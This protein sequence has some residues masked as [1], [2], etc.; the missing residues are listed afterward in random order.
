MVVRSVD[1]ETW[2]L[3]HIAICM[4]RTT[5]PITGEPAWW[6]DP[7]LIAPDGEVHEGVIDFLLRPLR[8]P[9]D[10]AVDEILTLAGKPQEV[11]GV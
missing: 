2:R 4:E 9:G 10:D 6:I 1:G 5:H 11:V 8:D 3:G 7:P